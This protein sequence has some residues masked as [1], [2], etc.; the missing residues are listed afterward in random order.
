MSSTSGRKTWL[1]GGFALL[2]V[3][4]PRAKLTPR[5]RGKVTSKAREVACPDISP[6]IGG[7]RPLPKL[8]F[9]LDG[10]VFF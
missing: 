6:K 5:E 7:F 8:T 9:R 2:Y 10:R 3:Y 1:G 4:K